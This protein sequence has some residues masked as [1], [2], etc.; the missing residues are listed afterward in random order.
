MNTFIQKG[1]IQLIIN[2]KYYDLVLILA[3]FQRIINL[4]MEKD[5]CLSQNIFYHID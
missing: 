3:Y 5:R 2:S 4:F 1:P